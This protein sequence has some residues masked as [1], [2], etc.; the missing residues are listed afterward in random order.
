MVVGLGLAV[1]GLSPAFADSA[2]DEAT[3]KL[4]QRVFLLCQSCH[5]TAE[6]A[7]NKIGPN[8]WGVFG[9]KAGTKADFRYSD[10]VS[11]SGITWSEQTIDQWI[12]NP[13]QFIS[14][15]RMA[16]RGV[17]NADNRK[18]LIAYLKQQTG[19]K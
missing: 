10:A 1:S 8:L 4:G 13:G 5:T 17:D 2:P 14:G 11:K 3:L 12:T 19:A 6:N 7:G 16:F 9:R 15:T 18:A